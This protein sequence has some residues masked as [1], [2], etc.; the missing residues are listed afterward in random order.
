MVGQKNSFG[1]GVLQTNA[2]NPNENAVLISEGVLYD[3][4]LMPILVSIVMLMT[5]I[6]GYRSIPRDGPCQR[7]YAPL[8]DASI[9]MSIAYLAIILYRFTLQDPLHETSRSLYSHQCGTQGCQ[10]KSI[11][12]KSLWNY[13][14]EQQFLKSFL[15]LSLTKR[16]RVWW[17]RVWNLI[18]C[19][20]QTPLLTTLVV[21]HLL[22]ITMNLGLFLYPDMQ[23]ES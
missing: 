9:A 15:L 4:S 12:R 23:E 10:K 6:W 3:N 18:F 11:I 19:A 13:Y 20:A 16:K 21:R 1:Y 7:F 14:A 22:R 8:S 2:P 17:R 5:G